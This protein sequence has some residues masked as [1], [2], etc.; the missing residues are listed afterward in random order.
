MKKITF[1]RKYHASVE[2]L[3]EAF[4]KPEI[5]KKW[6]SP[7]GMDC[8]YMTNDLV[9]GGLFH[10]CFKGKDGTEFWGRGIYQTIEP[11]TIISWYDSFA[12]KD[13]N[14]VPPSKYGLPGDEILETLVEFRFTQLGHNST[15][16]MAGDNPFDEA[17]TKEMAKGWNEMF[18]KLANL[19]EN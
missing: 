4:S 6:W 10:Y 7:E 13:G 9:P 17:M 8:S 12:D 14:A 19:L 15:L 1:E 11:S 5:L 18:D 3:W 16:A 2:K